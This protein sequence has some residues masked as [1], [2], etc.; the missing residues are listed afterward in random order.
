MSA[1]D[2]YDT[3]RVC[4]V[5][6]M[7]GPA[8][9]ELVRLAEMGQRDWTYPTVLALVA[10]LEACTDTVAEFREFRQ[11]RGSSGGYDAALFIH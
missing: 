6:R 9:E 2:R 1:L 11:E 7:P 10:E 3:A 5:L 4:D 8:G